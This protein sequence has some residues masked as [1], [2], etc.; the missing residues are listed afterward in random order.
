LTV[1][2]DLAFVAFKSFA[3]VGN[4]DIGHINPVCLNNQTELHGIAYVLCM[5][6]CRNYAVRLSTVSG[7]YLTGVQKKNN[8]DW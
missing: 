4:F 6:T 3:V 7:C 2:F 8:Y 5:L 1:L